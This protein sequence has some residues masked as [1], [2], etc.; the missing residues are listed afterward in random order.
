MCLNHFHVVKLQ[1]HVCVYTAA[2]NL[3]VYLRIPL[4]H[5]AP[6]LCT[7]KQIQPSTKVIQEMGVYQDS[8]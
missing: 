7:I 6:I 3:Y 1:K 4:F 8:W 2:C 5:K